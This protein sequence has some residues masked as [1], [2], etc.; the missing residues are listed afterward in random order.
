MV[1]FLRL[2]AAAAACA[3][4]CRA[5]GRIYMAS[6]VH[7]YLAFWLIKCPI[8][9]ERGQKAVS[10]AR[11]LMPLSKAPRPFMMYG[12]LPVSGNNLK[13][14]SEEASAFFDM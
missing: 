14:Q 9:E 12:S 1:F 5:V 6:F 13:R 8:F 3:P 2:D 4:R 11:N 7:F 10:R